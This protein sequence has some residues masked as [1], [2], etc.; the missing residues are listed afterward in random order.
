MTLFETYGGFKVWGRD[1]KDGSREFQ[2]RVGRNIVA[3]HRYL[4]EAL[5]DVRARVD[6]YW[7]EQARQLKLMKEQDQ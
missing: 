4:F 3:R 5:E 7:D 2:V 1:L 6:A